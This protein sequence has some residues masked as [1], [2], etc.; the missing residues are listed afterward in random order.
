ME[1]TQK[2]FAIEQDIAEKSDKA[3][4]YA[5]E[6]C[7][8]PTICVRGDASGMRHI[9]ISEIW[10]YREMV[11]LLTWRDIKLRY[12]QTVLGF[13]WAIIQ[14][15]LSTGLFTLVFGKLAKMPSNGDPYAIFTFA[16]LLPWAF[17]SNALGRC[18]NSLMANEV[19][20]GKVYFPRILL[21]LVHCCQV[22]SILALDCWSSYL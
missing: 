5:E 1:K 2:K 19:L 8:R 16:G 14:P 17:C 22:S 4:I 6:P 21:P 20:V 11:F 10:H 9:S 15:L 18:S 12:A 7:K 13:S 3:D